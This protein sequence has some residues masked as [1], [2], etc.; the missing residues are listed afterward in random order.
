MKGLK[1]LLGDKVLIKPDTESTISKGGIIIPDKAKEKPRMGVALLVGEGN[2]GQPMTVK[3]GDRV[4]YERY[5]TTDMELEG[6][7]YVVLSEQNI[8]AI[9]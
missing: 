8:M 2:E 3:K 6:E 7:T 5:A 9:I 4:L 1:L